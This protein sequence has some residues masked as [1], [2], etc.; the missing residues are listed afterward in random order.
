MTLFQ[1]MTS[2]Q[3]NSFILLKKISSLLF[4]FIT[5]FNVFGQDHFPSGLKVGDIAPEFSVKDQRENSIVLSEQIKDNQ[6]VVFFYRGRWCPVCT[7]HLSKM[8]DSLK[9]ITDKGINVIAIVPEKTEYIEKTIKR[10]EASFSILYDKD[11]QIMDAYKVSYKET[12]KNIQTYETWLNASF[13]KSHGNSDYT[14]PV[15]ATYIIDTTGKIKY[16]HFDTDYKNRASVKEIL[17]NL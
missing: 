4:L 13:E 11:H 16:V 12:G 14:L 3:F 10:T 1:N 15:P 7:K 5:Q 8:Q 2:F 6:L 17:D 9:F